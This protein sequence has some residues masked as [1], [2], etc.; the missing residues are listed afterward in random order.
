VTDLADDVLSDSVGA[1]LLGYLADHNASLTAATVQWRTTNGSVHQLRVAARRLRSA[2]L[3][4]HALLESDARA[5]VA[6]LRWFGV[7]L[8][9]LRDIEIV[10]PYLLDG[11]ALLSLGSRAALDDL[12]GSAQLAA[13]RR[14]G[15]ALDSTR[16]A[17]LRLRL[18]SMLEHTRL[19]D[20]A[21]TPAADYGRE[22][23]R[24]SAE[25]L[26]HR[27]DVVTV[28]V[29]R[30]PDTRLHDVRKAA[31]RLRYT[32]EVTAAYLGPSGGDLRTEAEN[33]QTVL[34]HH[35][36]RLVVAGWWRRLA[37]RLPDP[38]PEVES[39]V[40]AELSRAKSDLVDCRAAMAEMRSA[41]D[42][43]PVGS[44]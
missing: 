22:R 16:F 14:A 43:F 25:R 36:D 32:V 1:A 6:E 30:M 37:D 19:T 23:V 3:S 20:T 2:I 4:Y 24:R 44:V 15:V 11:A 34:G 28:D 42:A 39:L 40:S 12:V 38:V 27:I 10:G 31:K 9:D 8:S 18:R 7:E 26:R 29:P 5:V 21:R 33:M 17:A 41:I 35:Q 13:E